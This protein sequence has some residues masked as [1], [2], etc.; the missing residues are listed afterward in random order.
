MMNNIRNRL[1]K[2]ADVIIGLREVT[3]NNLTIVSTE[4]KEKLSEF[5]RSDAELFVADYK[6]NVLSKK[7][8]SSHAIA[9]LRNE[10]SDEIVRLIAAPS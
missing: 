7:F 5:G 1:R 2:Y 9:L 10:Y 3:V 6:Y 8:G 4:L